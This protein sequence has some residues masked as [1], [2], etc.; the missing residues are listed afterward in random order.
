MFF[1]RRVGL[2]AAAIYA[3]IPWDCFWSLHCFHPQQTQCFSLLCICAFYAAIRR[4]DR[5]NQKHFTR[6]CIFFCLTYLSWEGSGFL[7]PA[8]TLALLLLH[9]GRWGWL[10]ERHFWLGLMVVGAVIMLQWASR[11]MALPPYLALGY[12]LADLSTPVLY[13]LDPE[14]Q[15]F[16]YVQSILIISPYLLLTIC[17]CGSLLMV[18]KSAN[19][20]FCVVVYAVLLLSYS[21][22]LKAYSQRYGYYYQWILIVGA[23]AVIFESIRRIYSLSRAWKWWW[24]RSLIGTTAFAGLDLIFISATNSGLMFYRLGGKRRDLTGMRYWLRWQDSA[25][26]ARYVWKHWLPGDIVIGNLSQAFELYGG[27]LPDYGMDT[28]LSARMI[29]DN[30]RAVPRYEHR[31]TSIPILTDVP[32]TSDVM[33][34]ASR[35]W[36]VSA[37]EPN[38]VPA[39]DTPPSIHNVI[40]ELLTRQS[41]IVFTCYSSRVYLYEGYTAVPENRAADL[42][43]SPHP[44]LPVEYGSKLRTAL[45]PINPPF[46]QLPVKRPSGPN[47]SLDENVSGL[48]EPINTP[49]PDQGLITNPGSLLP[50]RRRLR[51]RRRN[52]SI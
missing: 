28:L 23:S 42:S 44:P 20:R 52:Y 46:A 41:R 29:Y 12:G 36:F 11:T 9:P 43:V 1:N 2:F 26:S 47:D 27:K 45:T 40:I 13:F 49:G 31:L 14:C 21:I 51:R 18:G 5:I 6:T 17:F 50:P 25:S 15:P 35:V 32:M 39:P 34:R 33:Q 4:P 48:V 30:K 38:V 37:Y 22:L 19:Y 8:F 7:L 10:R 3:F 16:Y 24:G